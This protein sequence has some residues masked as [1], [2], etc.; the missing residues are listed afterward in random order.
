MYKIRFKNYNKINKNVDKSILFCYL[1]LGIIGIIFIYSASMVPARMGSLTNGNIINSNHFMVRQSIFLFVGT[2]I[3]L[4]IAYFVDID[5]LKAKA[6][7]QFIIIGVIILLIITLIL[8]SEINGSK[9]WLN[10]GFFSIQSSE[11]LKL[12]SIIYLSYIIDK[13]MSQARI[14][15]IKTLLPPLFM[16]GFGLVLILVQGDLG[17]TIL[18]IGI[19]LFILMYSDIK[20]IV[21]IQLFSSISLPFVIYLIYTLIFDTKNTYRLNRI[22]VIM[23]PF[24]YENGEGYQ[25]SNSL[26]AIG[27]GG[28]TGQG[29]GN[30]IMKLGYLPE[31]HTDFIFSVLAEEA[32]LIG[33]IAVI[34]LYMYI[35][36]KGIIY[37]NTTKNNYYKIICIGVVSYLFLQVFINL[38]GI[39]GII[40]L[41]GVTLPLLSYGGSSL[42]SISVAFGLLLATTKKINMEKD[43]ETDK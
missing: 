33:V 26:L 5:A 10:L 19:I 15:N 11:F 30:G 3:V 16:L 4:F 13:K 25:L 29:M 43:L 8:G 38:A 34:A 20:N 1:I 42:L 37:A 28:V 40:P 18:N 31:P 6:F 27:N 2:L 35:T 12:A 14:Y 21:K 39:S 32:G 17:G 22:K 24:K 9:N 36:F 41:T 23:E 7:Q